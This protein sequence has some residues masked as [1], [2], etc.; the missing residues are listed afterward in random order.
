MAEVT[1]PLTARWRSRA[2]AA[3]PRRVTAAGRRLAA[4]RLAAWRLAVPGLAGAGLI[5]AA[6]GG[7]V[8]AAAGS[9]YGLWAGLGMA[10]LFL[11][12]VDSR[13]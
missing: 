7:L 9:A 12:R 4:W 11:L 2:G 13:L 1:A 6:T 10:G 8:T 3:V 5:S